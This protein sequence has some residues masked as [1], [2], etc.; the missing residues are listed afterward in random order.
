MDELLKSLWDFV[1]IP[2]C[3]VEAFPQTLEDKLREYITFL[4]GYNL[5]QFEIEKEAVVV[6]VNS[7][8]KA[9]CESVKF[10]YCGQQVQSYKKIADIS[11]IFNK[12]F[13]EISAKHSFY[14]MRTIVGEDKNN[15]DRQKMFHVPF[16][17]RDKIS[18]QRYSAPGFPCL[19]LGESAIDC[20]ME[21]GRPNLNSCVLSRLENVEA[22][23]LWDLSI[24]TSINFKKNKERLE[25]MLSLFPLTIASMFKVNNSAANF[26]PEYIIPQLLLE[27][28]SMNKPEVQGI[29]Y[30]SVWINKDL[31]FPKE[32]F[33][34]Y[35]I[36]IHNIENELAAP[37]E[38]SIDYCPYLCNHFNISNPISVELEQIRNPRLIS[39][40][41]S[42]NEC[43]YMN[44]LF[45]YLESRLKD[46][47][48]FKLR[49]IEPTPIS[50]LSKK[51]VNDQEQS[52]DPTIF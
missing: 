20:W 31:S 19:Y 36:P 35:V 33:K 47:S 14:R 32:L 49:K 10:Y 28:I 43:N 26:K 22:I 24:P 6:D 13:V 25:H 40:V 7:I 42:Q 9:L 48:E 27:Y 8:S 23:K 17:Q 16:T 50:S 46:E 4:E 52:N 3:S 37:V 18:T 11:C 1:P 51:R 45:G 21:L 34:N 15:L 5:S 39:P 38:M 29:A 41:Y 44:S 12:H 2:N 30:T